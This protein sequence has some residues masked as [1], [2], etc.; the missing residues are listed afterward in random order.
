VAPGAAETEFSEVRFHGDKAR[1]KQTYAGFEPLRAADIAEVV[2][3]AVTRPA[4]VCINDLTV[5]STAQ[6]NNTTIVRR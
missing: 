1:A 2:H 3:F 5:T 4:H 6:A